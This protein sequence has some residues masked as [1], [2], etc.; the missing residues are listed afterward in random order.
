[1]LNYTSQNVFAV[2]Y[3]DDTEICPAF[4]G[5][6]QTGS[7]DPERRLIIIKGGSDVTNPSLIS[8]LEANGTL[9]EAN[10]PT[11]TATKTGNDIS[12]T[13]IN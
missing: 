4:L 13:N 12:I 3:K 1:M 10:L 7:W 5:N 8:W 2:V 11:P 6:G 9:E